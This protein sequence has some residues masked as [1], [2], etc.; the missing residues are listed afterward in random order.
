M[1]Q[2]DS[3][4]AVFLTLFLLRSVRNILCAEPHCYCSFKV[5]L[6][7]EIYGRPRRF[8]KPPGSGKPGKQMLKEH[9]Y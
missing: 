6:S 5:K 2:Q 4:Q 1:D 7:G 8:S 3:L 9:Y